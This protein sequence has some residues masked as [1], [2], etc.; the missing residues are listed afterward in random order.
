MA[1]SATTAWQRSPDAAGDD[2]FIVRD[3]LIV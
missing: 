3:N 1:F 2:W